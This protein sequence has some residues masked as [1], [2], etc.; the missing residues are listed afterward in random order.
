MALH[1]S[2]EMKKHDL[3]PPG[4]LDIY[5]L[6]TLNIYSKPFHKK[7]KKTL[8]K[9]SL[10]GEFY[11]IFKEEKNTNTKTQK[12]EVNIPNSFCEELGSQHNS[13]PKT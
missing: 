5:L 8:S 9:V 7:K 10:T 6:K 3:N 12:I 1:F 2:K 4:E 11:Q 13:G